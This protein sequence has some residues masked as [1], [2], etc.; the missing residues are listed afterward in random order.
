MD[1]QKPYVHQPYPK[2][3]YHVSGTSAI[4]QNAAEHAAIGAGWFESPGE[5]SRGKADVKAAPRSETPEARRARLEAELAALNAQLGPQQPD[6]V[7]A[8]AAATEPASKPSDP[9]P[10]APVADPPA[11]APTAEDAAAKA[12]E[13]RKEMADAIYAS[14][15]EDIVSRI[16][17]S[18]PEALNTL[19]E[20]E[21]A[22]PKGPRTTI[23]KAVQ[24]AL[25]EIA[26]TK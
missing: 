15:V 2:C 8:A 22:N 18:S 25:L 23:V 5:A 16:P 24:K 12:A 19:I 21:A 6:T 26:V 7:P 11:A 4:V 3:L 9:V 10:A 13:A 14:K 20:I 1:P 17:G